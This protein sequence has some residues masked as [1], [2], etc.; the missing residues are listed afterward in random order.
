MQ[1][2]T[3]SDGPQDGDIM[4]INGRWYERWQSSWVERDGTVMPVKVIAPPD[5]RISTDEWVE[6]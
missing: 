2:A 4:L 6:P 1:D 3:G 5:W